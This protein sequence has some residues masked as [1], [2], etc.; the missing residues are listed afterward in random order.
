MPFNFPHDLWIHAVQDYL[1]GKPLIEVQTVQSYADIMR[2]LPPGRPSVLLIDKQG[3]QL[4]D[5]AVTSLRSD[6]GKRVQLPVD[7]YIVH[8][9]AID[10]ELPRE[11]RIDCTGLGGHDLGGEEPW[12]ICLRSDRHGQS[13]YGPSLAIMETTVYD[14]RTR[15]VHTVA[16][17]RLGLTKAMH[18]F[19]T[20][21]YFATDSASS[22]D[23]FLAEHMPKGTLPGADQRRQN[24]LDMFA[25]CHIAPSYRRLPRPTWTTPGFASWS[26]EDKIPMHTSHYK[27]SKGSIRSRVLSR[28]L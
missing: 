5:R 11:I 21:H 10:R 3:N 20:L 24:T 18:E 6:N 1:D 17:G 25:K 4:T 8:E 2:L 13:I 14:P 9:A 27:A 12:H 15:P 7:L 28:V 16:L 19:L 26:R 23:T 22:W